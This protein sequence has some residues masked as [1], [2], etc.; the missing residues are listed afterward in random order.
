M[1]DFY[2]V[3]AKV[4]LMTCWTIL[5]QEIKPLPTLLY[6]S[7]MEHPL[8]C[9]YG[10]P[11]LFLFQNQYHFCDHTCNTEEVEQREDSV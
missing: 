8:I 6:I 3:G 5:R 4:Q 11:F 7:T 9:F 1:N 10:K 2:P